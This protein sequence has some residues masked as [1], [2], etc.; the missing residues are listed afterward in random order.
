MDIE[1]ELHNELHKE[2]RLPIC[3]K[4]V[5][6]ID[7]IKCRNYAIKE[8]EVKTIVMHILHNVKL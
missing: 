8:N 3:E 1:F 2:K 7:S 6:T 5:I 4:V